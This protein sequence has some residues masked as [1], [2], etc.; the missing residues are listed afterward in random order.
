MVHRVKDR[1][2]DLLFLNKE[3]KEKKSDEISDRL[4]V[5][6]TAIC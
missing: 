4:K 1:I 2:P 3:Y 5:T 6:V